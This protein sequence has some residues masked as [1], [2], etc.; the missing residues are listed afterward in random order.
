MHDPVGNS[1]Q[2]GLPAVSRRR[3]SPGIRRLLTG[4]GR[5]PR[6]CGNPT[7]VA[8][9]CAPMRSTIAK[10]RTTLPEFI[11]VK[12]YCEVKGCCRA[13]AFSDM[14]RV[15]GLGVKVGWRTHIVRDVALDEMARAQ[16]RQPWLPLKDRDAASPNNR[17]MKSTRPRLKKTAARHERAVEVRP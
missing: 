6:R 13:T 16:E 3:E 17:A 14:R 7:G 4:Q 12:Q 5:G 11:T 1:R 9:E 10:L 15:P 8:L 2:K